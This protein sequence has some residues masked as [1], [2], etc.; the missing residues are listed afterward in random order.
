MAGKKEEV[1]FP[2]EQLVLRNSE[3]KK[4]QME[5]PIIRHIDTTCNNITSLLFVTAVLQVRE[6][7]ENSRGL[8]S[9]TLIYWVRFRWRMYDDAITL[10]K[11]NESLRLDQKSPEISDN[12]EAEM[13]N[14]SET[15]GI[16]E[17]LDRWMVPMG[18][19]TL[20]IPN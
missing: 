14:W 8:V 13:R 17:G 9:S 19:S 20:T 10:M 15:D 7:I 1:T 4:R 3:G 6:T 16:S 2:E 11:V 5:K 12:F 18:V